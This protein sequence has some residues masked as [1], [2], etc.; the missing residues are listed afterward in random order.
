MIK[1][2]TLHKFT[3]ILYLLNKLDKGRITLTQEAKELGFSVR[4]L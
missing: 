1:P 2:A 3:R 4:T